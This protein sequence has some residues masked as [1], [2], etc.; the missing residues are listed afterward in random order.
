MEKTAVLRELREIGLVPV[1]RADSVEQA[2]ALA[3]AIAAGGVTVLE[4]TM[5]VPGAIEVMRRLAEQ[6]PEILIGAG[7]VLDAETA[8]MCILE[9]AQFVVSPA[10]NVATIEMCHRYSVTVLPGALTPTEI[11]T[12]WQAGADV[13]KVFPASAMGGPKYLTSLKG[14][15]PHIEMIPTGGVVLGTAAEFLEAGA[16]ALGVGSD[17][18]DKKMIADGRPEAI[19][20]I[21]RRYLEIVKAFRSRHPI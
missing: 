3:D 7:T 17:L 8:R 10:L 9:G 18:V 4:V 1:L 13:V 21:A 2:L 19:T 14:P 20:D 5:T 12:A 15:L 6:R 16:F 11:V